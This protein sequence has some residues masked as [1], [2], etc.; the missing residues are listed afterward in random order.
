MQ[1][2]LSTYQSIVSTPPSH[3]HQTWSPLHSHTTPGFSTASLRS[4]STAETTRKCP[5]TRCG[6]TYT[7]VGAHAQAIRRP[8]A[9]PTFL[10]GTLCAG[11]VQYPPSLPYSPS[12]HT[13]KRSHH[14]LDAP[15][16]IMRG[17]RSSTSR[18]RTTRQHHTVRLLHTK[19]ILPHSHIGP[20]VA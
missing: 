1:P 14:T 12:S 18:W 5:L 16:P 13:F 2:P 6:C 9:P 8:L 20:L 3:T 11:T 19:G 7:L 17:P 15:S 4:P 10:Q